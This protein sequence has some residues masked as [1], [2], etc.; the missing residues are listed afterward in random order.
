M[1]YGDVFDQGNLGSCVPNAGLG[2]L[3]HIPF[4]VTGKRLWRE[5]D[6]VGD[7]GYYHKVTARD[8]FP[9]TYPEQDTG[10]DGLSMA[11]VLYSEG[12][13][14][15]YQHAFGLEH[16]LSTLMLGP[17]IV[18][19]PWQ[20]DMFYPDSAGIVRPTGG[21]AGGHEIVLDGINTTH[22][23]VRFSNSWSPRWGIN[24]RFYMFWPDFGA[25]LADGGDA[26]LFDKN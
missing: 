9:G 11:K 24:G 8:P 21:E 7:D 1:R 4:H 6:V 14:S 10:S 22:K 23:W 15:G 25:L 3:N 16:V 18:G 17:M 20:N 26:V 5:S 2:C 12:L 13:I 19:I